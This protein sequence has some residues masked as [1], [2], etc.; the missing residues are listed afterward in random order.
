MIHKQGL[1]ALFTSYKVREVSLCV[2]LSGSAPVI[3]VCVSRQHGTNIEVTEAHHSK[4][5]LNRG[6]EDMTP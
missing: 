5:G 2:G 3:S 4:D 6:N 1:A